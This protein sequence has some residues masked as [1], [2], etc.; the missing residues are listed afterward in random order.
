MKENYL[1]PNGL[2]FTTFS[3]AIED[4]YPGIHARE[5]AAYGEYLLATKC[6]DIVPTGPFFKVYHWKEMWDFEKGTGL[7]LE[8]NIKENYLG[9]IMQSNWT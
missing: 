4:N 3:I 6:I 2:D 1:D 8:E 5:T 9:I 7:E